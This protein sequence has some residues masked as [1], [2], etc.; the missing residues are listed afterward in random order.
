MPT[1]CRQRLS[2]T[3]TPQQWFVDPGSRNAR[4][5]SSRL[6]AFNR[7]CGRSDG[8][9]QW[10]SKPSPAEVHQLVPQCWVVM[11]TGCSRGLSETR[12]PQQW[13]VDPLSGNA[14]RCTSRLSDFNRHCGRND[15]QSRWGFEPEAAAEDEEEDPTPKDVGTKLVQRMRRTKL[16]QMKRQTTKFSGHVKKQ[17]PLS[18]MQISSGGQV[19]D[20]LSLLNEHDH[21]SVMQVSADG[22]VDKLSL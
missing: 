1:G 19:E 16:V 21:I 8:K 20:R 14:R 13:F 18:L 10:G 9:T 17:F 5:C 22:H 2:E 15:G 12:T 7:H 6:A 11:P 3:E 4:R